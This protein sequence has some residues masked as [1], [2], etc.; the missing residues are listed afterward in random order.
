ME[1]EN[2]IC[3]KKIQSLEKQISLIINENDKIMSR[4]NK[5][6]AQISRLVMDN[7][8]FKIEKEEKAQYQEFFETIVNLIITKGIWKF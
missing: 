4:N 2:Q 3:H 1:N 6:I 5:D 8:L 7:M